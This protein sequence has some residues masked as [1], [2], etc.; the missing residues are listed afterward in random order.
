MARRYEFY[1][2][3]ARTIYRTSERCELVGYFKLFLPREHKV[4]ILELTCNVLCIT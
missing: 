2:R 4:Y 1:G 3:V